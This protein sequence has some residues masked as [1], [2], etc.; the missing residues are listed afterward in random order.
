M[1]VRIETADGR[2]GLVQ[3]RALEEASVGP[4]TIWAGKHVG[5]WSGPSENG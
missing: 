5:I 1:W 3:E 2:G 4:C